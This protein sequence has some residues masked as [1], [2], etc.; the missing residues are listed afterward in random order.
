MPFLD[1]VIDGSTIRFKRSTTAGESP[2]TGSLRPGEIAVNT[3]DGTM[4]IGGASGSYKAVGADNQIVS[5]GN[6]ANLTQTQQ[7]QTKIGTIVTTTDGRRWV[8]SG[9]GSKILEASYIELADITPVWSVISGKPSEFT[10]ASHT[11]G[12]ITN[13]GAIGGT[14]NLPLITTTSGVVTTGTFGSSANSFCQGNDARLSDA[15]TPTAHKASHSTGG[16]DALSPSDIGAPASNPAGITGA[17][18]ITNIVSLTQAEYDAL[19]SKNA[20]TLYVIT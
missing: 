8:Y 7:D 5:S 19:G 9:E 10:P 12:N 18:A 1:H 14:A 4:F 3:V 16:S 6:I 13:A 2:A 15:R 17:D 20:S 11:H